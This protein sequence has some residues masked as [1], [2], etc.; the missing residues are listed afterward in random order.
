MYINVESPND[1]QKLSNELKKG[2][3][4]VLYYAD[5]CGHCQTMKPEWK[6]V[7]ENISN[8]KNKSKNIN[9]AE[10]ESKHIGDLL[11]KPEVNGFPSIKMY[12][13]GNEV[14]NFEDERIADKIQSF[15][16][17]NSNNKNASIIEKNVVNIEDSNM[18]E[19]LSNTLS[20]ILGIDSMKPKSHHQ[21]HQH[22]QHHSMKHKSHH[23]MK[24]KS[25]HS[26]K[27]KLNGS[28]KCNGILIPK[29]CKATNNCMFDYNI[30]KCKK[31]SMKKHKSHS[32]TR[33][34]VKSNTNKIRNTTKNIFAQLDK[35]FRRISQEAKQD[36]HILKQAKYKL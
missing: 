19:D 24:P 18:E 4:M 5:W 30:K 28:N 14:A 23:S 34:N 6:K 22:H 15:A 36:S 16:F 12:N 33:S 9:I 2:D 25:H 27:H 32:K 17:K 13:S 31:K 29:I 20:K 3:W 10:I 21:H 26:M 1:A 35:S 11:N 7:V 8:C